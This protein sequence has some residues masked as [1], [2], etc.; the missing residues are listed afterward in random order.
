MSLSDDERKALI[1]LKLQ[2]SE[3]SFDDMR[4][5]FDMGMFSTA[6]NRLYYSIFYSISALLISRGFEAHS[7]SGNLSL[8]NLHF[9]RTNII[10]IEYSRLVR[11]IFQL[12]QSSDYDDYFAVEKEDIE[13]LIQPSNALLSIIHSILTSSR[14]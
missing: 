12:R 6:A 5:C 2:K 3:K 11:N 8:F 13:E 14:S 10:P 4:I 1:S 7:H 9:I